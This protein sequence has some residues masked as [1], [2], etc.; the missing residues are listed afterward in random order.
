VAFVCRYHSGF[1]SRFLPMLLLA[2]LCPSQI[3][4]V[5]AQVSPKPETSQAQT[6]PQPGH[7]PTEIANK[8]V[9]APDQ[10][11][12]FPLP[13]LTKDERQARLRFLMHDT[14]LNILEHADTVDVKSCAAILGHLQSLDSVTVL[15]PAYSSHDPDE[16]VLPKIA[17]G[18][19]HL[20]MDSEYVTAVTPYTVLWRFANLYNRDPEFLAKPRKQK[21]SLS[22]N[23]STATANF[24]YYDLSHYLG[25]GF[26]GYFAEGAEQYANFS[27]IGEGAVR[28]NPPKLA[29]GPYCIPLFGTI[30]KLVNVQTCKT[31]HDPFIPAGERVGAIFY[32]GGGGA[33]SFPMP[34]F[35][36]F[37]DIEG[38]LY[39]V[40]FRTRGSLNDLER[41]IVPEHRSFDV[42]IDAVN[43]DGEDASFKEVCAFSTAK[44]TSLENYATPAGIIR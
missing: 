28:L 17:P 2:L 34:A 11:Q 30:D 23:Y 19:P 41:L 3:T 8:S 22:L 21:E 32:G 5:F 44:Q 1:L 29:V 43:I 38:R 24:E 18:C 15:Q 9:C 12:P 26:W 25:P 31:A 40:D 35:F 10:I 33:N 36:A 42:F 6:A 20:D 7:S 16:T 39:R 4:T 14:P 27:K 37:I 13:L